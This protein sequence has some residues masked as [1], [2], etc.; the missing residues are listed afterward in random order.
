MYVCSRTTSPV[1]VVLSDSGGV[2]S[3]NV[4][5]TGHSW[6]GLARRYQEISFPAVARRGL[7]E[8]LVNSRR[9]SEFSSPEFGATSFDRTRRR[10]FLTPTNRERAFRDRAELPRV[11]D[12][13]IVINIRL[14]LGIA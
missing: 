6:K 3:T 7:C 13:Q 12:R 8:T 10:S 5:R 2:V 11:E 1:S 9:W 4:F 14:L